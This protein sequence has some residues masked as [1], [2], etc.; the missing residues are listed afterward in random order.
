MASIDDILS[1]SMINSY[2]NS[3]TISEQSRKIDPLNTRRDKYLNLS[4]V[5][6]AL[7]SKLGE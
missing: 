4:N 2:V 6:A 3:F 7:S 1:T 5:Y